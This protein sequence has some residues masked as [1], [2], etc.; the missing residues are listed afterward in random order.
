[1]FFVLALRPG[2]CYLSRSSSFAI[3]PSSLSCGFASFRCLSDSVILSRSEIH[4]SDCCHR[5][6]HL[7]NSTLEALFLLAVYIFPHPLT[8]AFIRCPCHLPLAV[9]LCVSISACIVLCSVM[10]LVLALSFSSSGCLELLLPYL[11]RFLSLYF[12]FLSSLFL[13]P[14]LSFSL[15]HFFSKLFYVPSF[16]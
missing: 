8:L 7:L 12:P 14:S 1:M 15:F 13:S 4:F 2:F 9:L 10:S 11:F 16:I 5:L 3:C 6:P